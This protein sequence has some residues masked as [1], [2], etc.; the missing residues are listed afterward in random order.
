MVVC[1]S[2]SLKKVLNGVSMGVMS[3]LLMKA[4]QDVSEGLERVGLKYR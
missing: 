3:E 4:T 1:W 2:I